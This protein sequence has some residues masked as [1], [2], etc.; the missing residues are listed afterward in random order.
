[1]NWY[2]DAYPICNGTLH[3][4]LIEDWVI[5]FSCV[6]SFRQKE[7][8]LDVSAAEDVFVDHGL[9]GTEAATEC[10]ATQAP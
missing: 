3:D 1:M 4:D 10:L 8:S 9:I 5:C 2:T 7:V 6:R